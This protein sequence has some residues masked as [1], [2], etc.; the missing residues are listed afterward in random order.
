MRIAFL[1]FACL[2]GSSAF[3]DDLTLETVQR[4]Q[5][6]TDREPL[7]R[8]VLFGER[9]GRSWTNRH[10]IGPNAASVLLATPT[11]HT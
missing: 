1:A 5:P 7:I 3:G 11:L 6:N 9:S 10:W 4:P 8:S 2:I